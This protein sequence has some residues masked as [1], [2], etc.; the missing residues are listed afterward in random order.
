MSSSSLPNFLHTTSAQTPVLTLTILIIHAQIADGTGAPLRKAHVRISGDRIVAIAANLKPQPGER[1]IDAKGLVLAPGFIDIHNHSTDGLE[2]DPLAESQI[3]QGITTIVLGAD[4]DSPWP[5]APY[6]AARRANP[7]SLNIAMMAG[8]AT[9]REQIM[10]KDF[11]RVATPD[12][13]TKMTQL[14]EQAMNEGAIGLS[15]G[16]EYDVASY[17]STDE[18]VAEAKVAAAHGG[19]YMTH[20]RDEGDKSFSALDEEIAIGERA[21]IPIEHS[22]IKVSTVSVWNKAPEYIRVIEAARK[23]GVDFL[24][25]CYPYDAWHS[26]IKVIMPDKQYENPA[27]VEKALRDN[28]GAQ[29]IT[30][31]EFKPNRAYENHNIAELAA[32]NHITPVEMYIRI[33]REGDA[34]N[35]EASVIVKV[36]DRAR[37]QSLLSAALGHGRQRRRHRLRTSARSRHL[38]PRSRR[39]RPRKALAHAA[40][41]RPQ[42]DVAPRPAHRLER[43][44]RHPR[45]RHRR[46][47]P[48]QSQNGTRPLHLR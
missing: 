4:G 36:H 21:H 45:R 23:R 47:H 1:I 13:I 34:A 3:A 9:I 10:G 28:G 19:F 17:S 2:S 46:P 20:I 32:T 42:N 44:R 5:I 33:I 15:T 41:S 43:S 39:L 35:T 22:H 6:L 38:P 14:V 16:L 18:V 37:H 8:H 25:D 40:R 26:N 11:R 27:S 12:E 24:A 29:N 48:L 30:I 7:P 31:T